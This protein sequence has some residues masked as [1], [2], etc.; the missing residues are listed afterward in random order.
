MTTITRLG[1]M[2]LIR[3]TDGD[4]SQ[5]KDD[6]RGES[7]KTDQDPSDKAKRGLLMKN[8]LPEVLVYSLNRPRGTANGHVSSDSTILDLASKLEIQNSDFLD[9]SGL[10]NLDWEGIK[11]QSVKDIIKKMDI[12]IS[13]IDS[14]D[15]FQNDK[16]LPLKMTDKLK[17]K[18]LNLN[19]NLNL[20][21]LKHETINKQ[22]P[23]SMN[24][25]DSQARSSKV[26]QNYGLDSASSTALGQNSQKTGRTNPMEEKRK[27]SESIKLIREIKDKFKK[28]IQP[29][30]LKIIKDVSSKQNQES[31]KSLVKP[32]PNLMLLRDPEKSSGLKSTI[33]TL[34]NNKKKS[35]SS[36]HEHSPIKI[37]HLRSSKTGLQFHKLAQP[38]LTQDL[39]IQNFDKVD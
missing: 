26:H 3:L 34:Q 31:T 22:R 13:R 27:T 19:I 15:D 8:V 23:P 30:Q 33:Q 17:V 7:D 37:D 14:Q 12:M 10:T 6:A 1:R 38:S 18:D 16:T 11:E 21:V 20:R 36:L 4:I 9:V 24:K 35:I 39:R 5:S 25:R 29:Q 32:M 2:D 28:K